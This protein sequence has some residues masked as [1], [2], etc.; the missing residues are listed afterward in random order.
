MTYAA[1]GLRYAMVPSIGGHELPTLD[2]TWILL[3]LSAALIAC[4]IGG[5]IFFRRRV[6]FWDPSEKA[7]DELTPAK[8]GN[9]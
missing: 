9:L 7:R 6:L 8:G 4:L 2:I 5:V 3:V 1:E